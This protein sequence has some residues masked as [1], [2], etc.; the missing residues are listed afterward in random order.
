MQVAA[1]RCGIPSSPIV[2]AEASRRWVSAVHASRPF[3]I[4]FA[5]G[6]IRLLPGAISYWMFWIVASGLYVYAFY[7]TGVEMTCARSRR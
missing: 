4:L 6:S 2:H 7:E 5:T 3:N 1:V